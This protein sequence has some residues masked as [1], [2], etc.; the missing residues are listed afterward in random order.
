[1]IEVLPYDLTD[2]ADYPEVATRDEV[3]QD[4]SKIMEEM[5]STISKKS[6]HYSNAQM[7]G[8]FLT[9]YWELQRRWI[10][11]FMTFKECW[12]HKIDIILGRDPN[13]GIKEYSPR[14]YVTNEHYKE[15]IKALRETFID[16]ANY[17]ILG[18]IFFE[19]SLKKAE[20]RV[21]ELE[22]DNFQDVK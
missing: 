12:V 10:R 17:S 14:Q 11:I 5:L 20:Q 3:Y 6:E 9:L 19:R 8:N 1:M 7:K 4:A 22:K 16:M 18:I 15:L 2:N 13:I 21:A